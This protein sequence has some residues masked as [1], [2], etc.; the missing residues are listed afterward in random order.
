MTIDWSDI[1]YGA[2]LVGALAYMAIGGLYYSPFLLGGSWTRLTNV[3]EGHMSNP[4]IYVCSTAV[5]LISSFLMAILTQAAGTADLLSGIALG[6]I[7]GLLISLVYMKNA[8]FGLM[9]RKVYAI[10]VV[11]HLVSF[12]VLGIVHGCW[13]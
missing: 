13:G 3:K 6:L 9:S 7:V 8:A 12:I 11:E 10:A 2:V 5:A 1:H 4:R